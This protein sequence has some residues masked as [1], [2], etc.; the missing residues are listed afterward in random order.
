MMKVKKKKGLEFCVQLD[1]ARKQKLQKKLFDWYVIHQRELPWRKVK[2]PYSVWISEVMLQQ[3]QVQTV[4]PYYLRFLKSFPTIGHLAKANLQHLLRVW[5]GLGYYSRARNLRQAARKIIQDHNGRFPESYEGVLALPGIGR[6][7]AG[8]ISS[9]A[10]NQRYPALDGNA[11]RVL[12]RLFKLRGDPKSAGLHALLW[13]CAQELIPQSNP[14]DFNQALMELGAT[15]CSP[16]RPACLRCPWQA[17]C[18]ARKEGIQE[19]LP[20]K[21]TSLVAEKSQWAV[22]VI[23]HNQRVLIVR[24]TEGKL[25]RDFWE[26]PGGE[27][28]EVGNLKSALAKKIWRDFGLRVRLRNRLTTI[29]HAITKRRITLLVYQAELKTSM[30]KVPHTQTVRWVRL[31]ELKKYP[32]ASASSQVVKALKSMIC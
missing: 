17:E 16:R 30:L 27:F 21:R 12:T 26:F 11:A 25:L 7:T 9:I 22:A 29:K 20:E 23:F 10:F 6:Y 2:D 19:L 3:T 15:L 13:K 1:P 31:D 8:A 18:L 24:R 28:N 32:F 5:A 14:G 4:I